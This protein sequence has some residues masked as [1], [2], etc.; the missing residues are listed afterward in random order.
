MRPP[1]AG[2]VCDGQG[3]VLLPSPPQGHGWA[4]PRASPCYFVFSS[5]WTKPL[6]RKLRPEKDVPAQPGTGLQLHICPEPDPLN[7][8]LQVTIE[9][10]EP[11]DPRGIRRLSARG[12]GVLGPVAGAPGNSSCS[13]GYPVPYTHVPGERLLSGNGLLN[14]LC[15]PGCRLPQTVSR[16]AL[17]GLEIPDLK[18]K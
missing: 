7:K 14:E 4:G 15:G 10:A 13:A 8:R 1:S 2:K 9:P 11:P 12:L 6:S 16:S 17:S 5:L 3:R 18:I